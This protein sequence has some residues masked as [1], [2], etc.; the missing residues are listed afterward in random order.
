MTIKRE[1]A[2]LA[3]RQYKSKNPSGKPPASIGGRSAT[4][5]WP[6]D[7]SSGLGGNGAAQSEVTI[8]FVTLLEKHPDDLD[9]LDASP[10]TR[11]MASWL[12]QLNRFRRQ[13][14][15]AL[16]PLRWNPR[17]AA[18]AKIHADDL[19]ANNMTGHIGSDGSTLGDRVS[20]QGFDGTELRE[21]IAYGQPVF[22]GALL[23][24]ELS[25]PHYQTLIASS[26]SEVGLAL[27]NSNGSQYPHYWVLVM[28]QRRY[29]RQIEQLDYFYKYFQGVYAYSGGWP[30]ANELQGEFESAGEVLEVKRALEVL[31]FFTKAFDP[32]QP[33]RRQLMTAGD[34][35]GVLMRAG[36]RL[37]FNT[38]ITFLVQHTTGQNLSGLRYRTGFTVFREGELGQ[39]NVFSRASDTVDYSAS[40]PHSSWITRI[41]SE[42]QRLPVIVMP[43]DYLLVYN[44]I[45]SG[46]IEPYVYDF[47]S[48]LLSDDQM[49]EG[50]DAA[51]VEDYP[52]GDPAETAKAQKI[53]TA[54]NNATD[55]EHRP[56][57][58]VVRDASADYGMPAGSIFAPDFSGPVPFGVPR[59]GLF[60]EDIDL[61]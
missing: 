2:R 53:L 31:D 21:N 20:A 43:G 52:F 47:D 8:R 50:F 30:Q 14:N 9:A 26:V 22:S 1:L 23:D 57:Q 15:P 34:G 46:Q 55:N 42:G 40:P 60:V 19:A 6:Q 29:G 4:M 25:P 11:E 51:L 38:I 41:S 39:L 17:L 54:A 37:A 33:H 28:G 44:Y 35:L 12:S 27:T 3:G 45:E 49:A 7:L 58:V 59:M 36:T 32:S 5:T 48:V 56:Q 24:W 61:N 10:L 13:Q 18:A 16:K